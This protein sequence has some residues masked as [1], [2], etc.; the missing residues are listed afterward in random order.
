L[1]DYL[2]QS[3]SMYSGKLREL[4]EVLIEWLNYIPHT[5]PHY[6]RHT[7]GHSDNIIVQLSKLLFADDDVNKPVLELSSIE[8]YVLCAAAMLHDSGMVASDREKASILESDEWHEWIEAG[9][10]RDRLSAIEVLRCSGKPNSQVTAF[11]ADLEL[12][13]LIAD[14]IRARHHRRGGEFIVGHELALGRFAFGDAALRDTVADICVAHGLRVDELNDSARYPL[15][16]DLR[17]EKINV[18]L[19]AIL[20]RLGDLLDMDSDRACPM[21]LAAGSPI[22]AGSIAHWTQYQKINHRL[23]SPDKIEITAECDTQE[24]HRVL[25]DWC[26]WIVSEARSA[27]ALLAASR[28][29]SEWR[30][31]EVEIG[32]G[33][34]IQIRPAR[35]AS[36][37]PCSWKLEI[38]EEAIFDRLINDV[39]TDRLAFVGELIQNSIDATRCKL[40]ADVTNS[41]ES[42]PGDFRKLSD[43][44]LERHALKISLSEIT[45][46]S[47]AS[48]ADEPVQLLEFDDSGIGMTP[49]IVRRFFLQIGRSFYRTPEFRRRF[50][51]ASIG[52]HGLGFLSV[53]AVSDRVVVE[54][55]HAYDM[56]AGDSLRL[57]LTGPRNY[58]LQEKGSRRRPGTTV[59]VLLRAPIDQREL[60]QYVEGLC[61]RVEIPIVLVTQYGKSV[62]KRELPVNLCEEVV[63][64]STDGAT[65]RVAAYPFRSQNVEGEMYIFERRTA[66]FT[67]WAAHSWAQYAYL[68]M[69]PLARI[70]VVPGDSPCVNGLDH[71]GRAHYS[72]RPFGLRFDY[73]GPQKSVSLDRTA[74]LHRGRGEQYGDLFGQ[75]PEVRAAVLE[76]LT[77]HLDEVDAKSEENAWSYYQRLADSFAFVDYWACRASTVRVFANGSA[78]TT[79]LAELEA[80]EI[81]FS[82]SAISRRSI[83]QRGEVVQKLDELEQLSSAG[84]A[85]A[86]ITRGDFARLSRMFRRRLFERRRVA[87]AALAPGGV[88]VLEWARSKP[89]EHAFLETSDDKVWTT[90][91]TAFDKIGYADYDLPGAEHGRTVIL[92]SSHPLVEWLGVAESAC[93]KGIGGLDKNSWLRLVKLVVDPI[94][95]AAQEKLAAL[96]NFLERWRTL[97]GDSD[98]SEPPPID[99]ADFH[100]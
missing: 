81:L 44:V 13:F 64:L 92:N 26:N 65:L 31:P 25:A 71:S 32:P 39:Y 37:V 89:D 1:L 99:P 10:G 100:Y 15:A 8:A 86:L 23:T 38:D 47:D 78:T 43:D 3:D 60:I 9:S 67:S 87:S 97:L 95:Y 55:R 84:C 11:L 48:S 77:K 80:R 70:P 68:P 85:E 5:F 61:K 49:D 50:P 79:S 45:V 76:M 72:Q 21:L 51:F 74:G 34:T 16:R 52:R 69:H 42:W 20:L 66:D 7:I 19:M 56:T 30:P 98:V 94:G 33:G 36:Y 59:R 29:H 57:T 58:F 28:R 17:G 90:R 62:L 40:Y 2:A 91:W 96:Q 53:F 27:P 93:A 41:G 35:S 73:R 4:R 24:E 46:K 88:I 18:R 6:T 83:I 22:P 82:A 12:R 54:T 14:F 75:Y 63:D